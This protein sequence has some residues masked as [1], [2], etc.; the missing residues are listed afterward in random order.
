VDAVEMFKEYHTSK[1]KGM[2]DEV[3]EIV[4]STYI[5]D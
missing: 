2:T 4:V 5:Y 3:K 1:K